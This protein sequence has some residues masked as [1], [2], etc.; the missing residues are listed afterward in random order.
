MGAASG[1]DEP[2]GPDDLTI[3]NPNGTVAE[4]ASWLALVYSTLRNP[5][6][7]LIVSSGPPDLYAQALNH[8]GLFVLEYRDGS[9]EK[10]FQAE[11]VSLVSIA[12]ALSQWTDGDRAFI[13][14]HEWTQLSI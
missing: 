14:D 8:D 13:S 10:H 4:P 12:D 5:G 11:G 3:R 2:I 6:D 1:D 7:F 9:P